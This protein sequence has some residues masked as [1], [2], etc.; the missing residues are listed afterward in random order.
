MI[1]ILVVLLLL[2]NR[3]P[4]MAQRLAFS[5]DDGFNPTNQPNAGVLNQA[6]VDALSNANVTAIFYVAGKRVDSKA[7]IELV[8]VWS[9][10]GHSIGNHTYNHP[11]FGSNR[12]SLQ[13]FIA[14]IQQNEQLLDT[15]PT[16]TKRL[17]FPYLKEGN[18]VAKRDSLRNWLIE[19]DY[20]SGA[21]SI[22]ASDW[23][24]D[25]RFI[26][27]QN[28]HPSQDSS[29]FRRAYLHHLWERACYYDS[30]SR[31]ILG[32]SSDH[33]LLLHTNSINAAFLKDAIAMFR[34][35]GWE[36][37]SPEEA[38]KD[39]LYSMLPSTIPAGESIIW[40]LAKQKNLSNLRYPAEDANYEQPIL[41]K[42]GL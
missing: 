36:I 41:D 27:W 21:V 42:L 34:N 24:Y 23:Y 32:R 29:E 12:V 17:R 33:V 19:H 20:R 38:Y 40:S 25:Q 28:A 7:G 4:G 3:T 37:I 6:I 9:K 13:Q 11:N 10:A 15:F 8:N 30:L 35:E 22:D 39:T 18:T 31:Q 14:D 1:R 16:W 26:Q 2:A 5:F